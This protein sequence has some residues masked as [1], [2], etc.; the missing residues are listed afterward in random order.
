MILCQNIRLASRLLRRNPSTTAIALL[1]IAISVAATCVVFAAIKSVLLAPLPYSHAEE[2]VQIGTKFGNLFEQSI[3]DFGFWRDAQEIA[4]RTRTLGSV[5]VYG[6]SMFTLAGSASTPPEAL[7]GLE[8]SA[9]L[10]PTLGVKPILGRNFLSDANQPGQACKMIL[11]YGLWSRRFNQDPNIVGQS[12]LGVDEH[13]CQI[14]GVM[15]AEFNFPLRRAAAHTPSPYVEFWVPMRLPP[16]H[17]EGAMGIVARLRNGVTVQDA[18]QDLASIS[19]ALTSEFPATNR[20]RVLRLGLLRDRMFG[21]AAKTLGLLMGGASMFLLIGCANVA[22]LLLARGFARER[23]IAIRV[24]VGATHGRLMQQL[25]TES[26][27]LALLG[28]AGGYLLT[29]AAWRILPAIAPVNI[30]RLGAARADWMVLAFALAV[31]LTSGLLFGLAPALRARLI[32]VSFVR[33]SRSPAETN[34]N[35]NRIHD[36]LVVAEVTITVALVVVGSQLLAQFIDSLR[37]DPG[38]QADHLLASVVAPSNERYRTP[39]QRAM[40]YQRLVDAVRAIPGVESAG[41]VD[42]LPFSGE[43]HGGLVSATPEQAVQTSTQIPAEIDVVSASYLQTLGVRLIAGRWFREDEMSTPYDTAIVSDATARRLWP[44]EDAIGK[45][46]C[47]YCTPESPSNWKRVVGVVSGVRHRSIDGPMP[48]N[49]YL[50]RGALERAMF[51]VV[52]TKGP[53]EGLENAIPGAIFGVDANQ[54]VFLTATLQTF[55]ADSIADRRFVTTLLVGTAI[56]ALLMSATGVYG[57]LSHTTSRRRQEIGV[58]IALGATRNDVRL[59][60]FRHG[61]MP[62]LAGLAVGLVLTLVLLRVLRG[63]IEGL[64]S[65]EWSS[66]A[67]SLGLISLAAA[68]ACFVPAARA[69]RIDPIS[70][71]RY[72]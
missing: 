26:A 65:G 29:V 4:R 39:Q 44:G 52:N 59:L 53:A 8:V 10:F 55:I 18:Q 64:G 30:P 27:V 56:L 2:L 28:G 9:N 37:S 23:E 17:P 48:L 58:R 6:N 40:A 43:N 19:A 67:I 38:F 36:S 70:A 69:T 62:V 35:S 14:I 68:I 3:V 46:I 32:P 11:S 16:A 1:S 49:V 7:Y 47:V 21:G 66:V 13:N 20:D 50:A 31:A 72:E 61:F 63:V 42:A 57:V 22:I 41:T 12:A 54:P 5:G 25:F 60:I 24:A 15:S 34:P 45:R 71:L 33:A 51:L